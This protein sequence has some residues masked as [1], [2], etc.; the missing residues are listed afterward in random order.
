MFNKITS[1]TIIA[2]INQ[3]NKS[4]IRISKAAPRIEANQG[5]RKSQNQKI[6]NPESGSELFGTLIVWVIWICFGFRASN[7]KYVW[8][9][10]PVADLIGS[11]Q[12]SHHIGREVH[13]GWELE[14]LIF[15]SLVHFVVNT[16]P[17]KYRNS[18]I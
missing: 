18:F 13:E 8:L 1:R 14:F 6:Q 2:A 4:E 15:V 16:P 10:F 7:F 5:Q 11:A 17:Q 9:V 12:F 3:R